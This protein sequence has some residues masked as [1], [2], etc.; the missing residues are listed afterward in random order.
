MTADRTM[1]LSRYFDRNR[2][3]RGFE[4]LSDGLMALAS[5]DG[6]DAMAK[7]KKADRLLNRPDLTNLIV[8]QAA[9]ANGDRQTA[10]ATYKKLLKDPFVMLIYKIGCTLCII[11]PLRIGTFAVIIPRK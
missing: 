10:K 7:A 8:A 5:G 2:E 11:Y 3:R 6:R 1:T 9:V 4:A